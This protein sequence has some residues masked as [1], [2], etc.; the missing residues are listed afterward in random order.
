MTAPRTVSLSDFLIW[1]EPSWSGLD[2][3]LG[4]FTPRLIDVLAP[5]YLNRGNIKNLI[6]CCHVRWRF[7]R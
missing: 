5:C 2:H 1:V 7:R 4:G 3:R 6:G